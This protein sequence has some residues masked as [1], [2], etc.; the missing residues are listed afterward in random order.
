M[1]KKSALETSG[2]KDVAPVPENATTSRLDPFADWF[3]RWPEMFA[4]RWPE[5]FHAM[6]SSF[7]DRGFR[8]EQFVDEDGALVVRGELPGLDPEQDVTI[9]VEG[10]RLKISGT[11]EERS[12]DSTDGTFRTEFDYGAF[13]RSVALPTGARTDDIT[14]GY[15]NGILEV[16]VPIDAERTEATKIPISTTG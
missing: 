15:T 13:E 4:R 5:S 6:T 11:R 2:R 3:D 9:V 14:A 10:D 8:M 16:R 1:A 7:A 12:E